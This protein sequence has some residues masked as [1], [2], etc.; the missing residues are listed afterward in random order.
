MMNGFNN[1]MGAKPPN[2][3]QQPLF[4]GHS[5]SNTLQ[6]NQYAPQSSSSP[7]P[8]DSPYRGATRKIGPD[9]GPAGIKIP[10]PMGMGGPTSPRMGGGLGLGNVAGSIMG[11]PGLPRSV[12]GD[13]M[14]MSIM[15]NTNSNAAN[16]INGQQRQSPRPQSSMGMN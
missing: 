15:G 13:T 2:Q 5:Q 12:S 4:T 7:P 6:Q 1:P 8:M 11:P 16:T 14:N 3:Q 10:M 9:A